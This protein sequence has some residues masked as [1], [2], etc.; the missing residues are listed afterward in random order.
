MCDGANKL[1]AFSKFLCIQD[2]DKSEKTWSSI[3][4]IQYQYFYESVS[5]CSSGSERTCLKNKHI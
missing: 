3:G 2:P 1:S 5:P 4:D